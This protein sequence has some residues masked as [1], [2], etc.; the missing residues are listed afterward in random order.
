[1]RRRIII[2]D[3]TEMHGGRFCVAGWD[4]TNQVMIRPLPGRAANW[5]ALDVASE[6]LWPGNSFS[7]D[8]AGG[9]PDGDHPHA[10]EDMRIVTNDMRIGRRRE[11]WVEAVVGAT[12]RTIADV[13]DGN[14]TWKTY[15][16][17]RYHAVV[18]RGTKCRS[19]GGLIAKS[20][21]LQFI[22]DGKES[23]LK[24]LI[25][26]GS[27]TYKLPVVAHEIRSLYR[28]EG[29][30]ALQK[31]FARRRTHVR[32]GLARAY[33]DYPDECFVMLNGVYLF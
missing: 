18:A 12:E 14:M 23:K 22:E 20:G 16:G 29:L 32:L 7:F 33:G 9:Q 28:S 5:S 15:N 4:V 6:R 11:N 13:F 19:L 21:A 30:A 31:A 10:T 27:G 25:S 3:V 2:T 24:A 17:R 8:E 1:M 26:D